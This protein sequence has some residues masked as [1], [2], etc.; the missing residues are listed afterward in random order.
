M[1]CKELSRSQAGAAAMP[2]CPL[3]TASSFDTVILCFIGNTKAWGNATGGLGKYFIWLCL[4]YCEI[5]TGISKNE[6]IK[7]NDCS[8]DSMLGASVFSQQEVPV[9]LLGDTE[10][11]ENRL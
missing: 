3:H 11:Q 6:F 4:V 5:S 7:G 9:K 1:K 8:P 10:G 2:V